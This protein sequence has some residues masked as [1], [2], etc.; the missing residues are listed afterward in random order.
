MWRLVFHNRD[1]EYRALKKRYLANVYEPE[2][3][4]EDKVYP[5]TYYNHQLG[6]VTMDGIPTWIVNS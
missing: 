6:S 1:L 2:V 5:E 3:A 4:L